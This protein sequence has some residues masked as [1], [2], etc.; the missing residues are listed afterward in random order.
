MALKALNQALKIAPSMFG[1]YN[2]IGLIYINLKNYSEAIVN[3][4]KLLMQI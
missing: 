2:N 3:F 4:K 1:I